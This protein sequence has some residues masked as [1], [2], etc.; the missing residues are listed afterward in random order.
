MASTAPSSPASSSI[1]R[2][3]LAQIDNRLGDLEA[4]LATHRRWVDSAKAEGVELLVFPELSLTGY[5]LLHLT[6]RVALRLRESKL[7]A[8]LAAAAGSMAT[9]VGLV[10]EDEQ[11]VLYN[12]AVLVHHGQIVHVHRKLYLPSYG[13]FQEGRFFGAGQGLSSVR[14][15]GRSAALGVLIC[16][17]L[18]HAELARKLARS[19]TKL[20]AVISASPG[21]VGPGERPESQEDWEL[22][23]RGAAL[24]NTSWVVYCNR[25]GWEEGTFYTG[26]SHIVRPGGEVLARAPYLDEHLLVADLDL[27]EVD[28]LRWKLPLLREERRDLGGTT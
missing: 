25:V 16:E 4:N 18:W 13:I 26:G 6:P 1:L 8:D 17:D 2:V 10:E 28:R 14:L 21:R 27:K 15:D 3:G 5:R 24:L 7:L 20:L 11:G 9:L 19:G 22:L 23:T 12:S